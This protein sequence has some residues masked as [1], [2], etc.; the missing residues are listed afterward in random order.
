MTARIAGS[1][2]VGDRI[3]YL[4]GGNLEQLI[5][6]CRA[7]VTVNSTVGFL[8]LAGGK[9]TVALGDAIYDMSGL[10]F[11]LGLDRFWT[12]GRPPD[13]ALFDSFRRVAVAR[14][15]INGGFFS[16]A[17]LELAV[18]GT[19]ERLENALDRHLVAYPAAS[20]PPHPATP[21]GLRAA[22]LVL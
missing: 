14:A 4:E 9:P 1:R 7:V 8:A 20:E 5:R 15:Q 10:T 19:V 12:E 22:S 11:Q 21:G 13:P 6:D 16:N 3:F 2:G 18:S 17:G